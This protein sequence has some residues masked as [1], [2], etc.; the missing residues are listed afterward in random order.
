LESGR[1]AV[2]AVGVSAAAGQTKADFSGRKG[3]LRSAK[4]LDDEPGRCLGCGWECNTCVEVCPNRANV[5]IGM[6]EGL[7]NGNQVLHLDGPCNACGNCAT[8]CPYSGAPYRDKLTLFWTDD[9]FNNSHNPGFVPVADGGAPV[10]KVR[11]DGRVLPMGL[12]TGETAVGVP[13]DVAALI[14]TVWEQH[15]YLFPK[16]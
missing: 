15:R 7:R 16:K 12:S 13:G 10:F 4:T 1:P 6:T 2:P 5:V 3:V 8:F 14:R 11:L 9:D